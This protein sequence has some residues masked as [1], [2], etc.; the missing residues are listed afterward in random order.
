MMAVIPPDVRDGQPAHEFLQLVLAARAQDQMPV[1]WHHA[2]GEQ[3][4]AIALQGFAK[5]VHEGL[6][7]RGFSEDAGSPVPPVQ[8][9]VD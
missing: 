2:P 6:I 4:D 5:A 8:D 3:I 7:I 1:V 9:V